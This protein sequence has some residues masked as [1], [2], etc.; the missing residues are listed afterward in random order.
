MQKYQY[1]EKEEALF[2]HKSKY[3]TSTK[4]W[5]DAFY[6]CIGHILKIYF[7]TDKYKKEES[8][9]RENKDSLKF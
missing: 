9:E 4:F 6:I 8:T 5:Q 2:N 7:Q 3:L 1:I